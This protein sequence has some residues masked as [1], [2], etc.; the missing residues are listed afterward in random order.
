MRF[1]REKVILLLLR[2]TQTGEL[3]HTVVV[4][5]I[6]PT[7]PKDSVDEIRIL[8][9]DDHPI[10]R[11]GVSERVKA[12]GGSIELVGEASDGF[13]AQKLTAALH[14]HV[15]L[16]DLDMPGISGIE[17]TRNIKADYPEIQI[18]ILSAAAE[19]D[20]IN[21]VLQAGANGFLLKSVTGPELQEAIFAVIAGGSVL[22]PS[23]TR[24]LLP[25]LSHPVATSET[26]TEREIEILEMVSSGATNKNIGKQIS[27]SVRTVEAH[28]HN[29]FQKLG[30]S[31]R[32]EAVT[33]A[34]RDGLI[35]TSKSN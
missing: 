19:V 18:I 8:I 26:L 15:I 14:P 21:E 5:N 32:T 2:L 7:M 1:S 13:E 29:I 17:V 3:G 30:V 27:L 31:S 4:K 28:I 22:S 24:R 25:L 35:K 9:V 33:Q 16:M 11:L 10:F 34:I 23:V 12:I 6:E 20:E